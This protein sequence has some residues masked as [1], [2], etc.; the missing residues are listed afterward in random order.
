MSLSTQTSAATTFEVFLDEQWKQLRGSILEKHRSLVGEVASP[1]FG[2][3]AADS[4]ATDVSSTSRLPCLP[5]LLHHLRNDT[6]RGLPTLPSAIVSPPPEEETPSNPPLEDILIFPSPLISG[7]GMERQSSKER[8]RKQAACSSR[9]VAPV[10]RVLDPRDEDPEIERHPSKERVAMQDRQY[11]SLELPRNDKQ[12]IADRHQ[13]HGFEGPSRQALPRNTLDVCT[14]HAPSS[15]RPS[16]LGADVAAQVS[17]AHC[18]PQQA[19]SQLGG[20]ALLQT[21]EILPNADSLAR[22]S[23]LLSTER[24]GG[25]SRRNSLLSNGSAR[26]LLSF[27]PFVTPQG[28]NAENLENIVEF[29]ERFDPLPIWETTANKAQ[30]KVIR[31]HTAASTILRQPI[32]DAVMQ[33]GRQQHCDSI[34]RCLQRTGLHMAWESMAAA[35]AIFDITTGPLHLVGISLGSLANLSDWVVR[36]FWSLDLIFTRLSRGEVKDEFQG[37][38]EQPRCYRWTSRHLF[39]DLL[40]VVVAWAE[41]WSESP[42]VRVLALFRFLRIGRMQ[43]V[44]EAIKAVISSEKLVLGITILQSTLEVL[45]VLH[46][47]ACGWLFLGRRESGWVATHGLQG[48]DLEQCALAYHWAMAQIYGTMDL[49]PSDVVERLFAVSALLISFL[50][51]TAFVSSVT[52]SITRLHIL[53]GQQ[54]AHQRILR[55]YLQCQGISAPLA[56]RVQQ[57]AKNAVAEQQ[58]NI[59]EMDVELLKLVSEPLRIHLHLEMHSPLLQA[60]PLFEF[61]QQNV[62][63][64]MRQICHSAVSAV[65]VSKADVIFERGELPREPKMIFLRKGTL[66]YTLNRLEFTD[67]TEGGWITEHVLWTSWVYHGTLWAESNCHLLLLDANLF[68]ELASAN[69]TKELNFAAYGAE[70]LQ[71]V[72]SEHLD[73][74]SDMGSL[75]GSLAC[76]EIAR[77]RGTLLRT[78]P[79]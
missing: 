79:S 47:V 11:P 14:N 60:H 6:V 4:K 20:N 10:E 56:A 44:S 39:V 9:K 53:T 54:G 7:P 3:H 13:H 22:R 16:L 61:V 18:P 70:F 77:M 57:N 59:P 72:N 49:A 25:P 30:G 1:L 29:A 46:L 76:L 52:S 12:P 26:S 42:A 74:R 28:S 21:L 31:T 27:Q 8:V 15:R 66:R 63:T 2:E 67:L 68:Q 62:P 33:S 73:D 78:S 64:L 36:L 41:V 17:Q 5:N 71:R 19:G 23:S 55:K 48:Q 32:K 34:Q 45:G 69:Q 75:E 51:A 40:L 58:R 24:E 38:V 43:T 37:E 50:V 35:C 65:T